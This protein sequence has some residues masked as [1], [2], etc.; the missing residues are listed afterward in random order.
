MAAG[1]EQELTLALE[2]ELRARGVILDGTDVER[3]AVDIRID[4][5]LDITDKH[6]PEKR[7]WGSR[8]RCLG[9]Y[10]VLHKSVTFNVPGTTSGVARLIS[11]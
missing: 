5:R 9:V 11:W 1:L 6:H 7:V 10:Y 4:H 2:A 3:F 8:L